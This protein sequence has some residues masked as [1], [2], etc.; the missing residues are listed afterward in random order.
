MMQ[1][2]YQAMVMEQSA[3]WSLRELIDLAVGLGRER[4]PVPEPGPVPVPG[5][6]PL[7]APK[8]E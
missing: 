2:K 5:L 8:A 4:V 7:E 1:R 6:R 3:L